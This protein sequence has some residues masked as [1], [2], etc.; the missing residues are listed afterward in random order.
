VDLNTLLL[1]SNIDPKQVLVMRH[2]PTEDDLR[3]VLPWLASERPS[4]R[5]YST[6]IKNRSGL[7]LKKL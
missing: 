6:R 4:V 3:Q 5:A 1:E 7:A 2:R